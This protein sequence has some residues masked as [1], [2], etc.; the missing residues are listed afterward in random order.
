M[1]LL[2]P[3]PSPPL[4]ESAQG[5]RLIKLSALSYSSL[6]LLQ[7]IEPRRCLTTAHSFE[8]AAFRQYPS[9]VSLL[10][11][12]GLECIDCLTVEQEE[13]LAAINAKLAQ[14]TEQRQNRAN[15]NRQL[16]NMNPMGMMPPHNMQNPMSGQTPAQANQGF[17]SQLQRPMQATP[18][19][20]NH[21][22]PYA[23]GMVPQGMSMNQASGAQIM[24]QQPVPNVTLTEPELQ[25]I[26]TLAQQKANSMTQDDKNKV[27]NMVPPHQREQLQRLGDNSIVAICRQQI[28]RQFMLR[29]SSQQLRN[30]NVA[31]SQNMMPGMATMQGPQPAFGRPSQQMQTNQPQANGFH[32]SQ[33]VNVTLLGQQAEAQKSQEAGQVVVPASNNPNVSQ[34]MTSQQSMGAQNA[35]AQ[36]QMFNNRQLTNQQGALRAQQQQQQQ[37][38]EQ[39]LKLA[40]ANQ[41]RNM[42]LQGQ[43]GGLNGS[44]PPQQ[45]PAMPNLNRPMVPPGSNNLQS[46]QQQGGPAMQP[47]PVPMENRMSQQGH[48][49]MPNQQGFGASQNAA[50]MQVNRNALIPPHISLELR[51][52]LM[53]MPEP[54]FQ[55]ALNQ[56]QQSYQRQMA[57]NRNNNQMASQPQF[58]MQPG[59]V[60]MQQNPLQSGHQQL[61]VN[62]QPQ[63]VGSG[64]QQQQPQQNG[65]IKQLSHLQQ[66]F[67][68]TPA[69]IAEWD[70]KPAPPQIRN[71][72]PRL[73][74]HAQT[75]GQVKNHITNAALN[76]MM[77]T[78][79][80]HAQSQHF[81][82]FATQM[83][84][85]NGISNGTG[86]AGNMQNQNAM[87]MAANGPAPPAQMVAPG[88]QQVPP[89]AKMGVQ[90]QMPSAFTLNNLAN[91]NQAQIVA[92]TPQDL[93]KVRSRMGAKGAQMDDNTIRQ[94]LWNQRNRMQQSP[95]NLAAPQMQGNMMNQQF[96]LGPNMM[97]Q[98]R[99]QGQ[100]PVPQPQQTQQIQTPKPQAKP[101][102]TPAKP[103]QQA[104]IAQAQQIQRGQKRPASNDDVMEV[105]PPKVAKPN[106]APHMQQS[107]S[108]QG[109]PK[110]TPDPMANLKPEEKAKVQEQIRQ[111]AMAKASTN[112]ARSLNQANG[113]PVSAGSQ[114]AS[115]SGSG[116][117]AQRFQLGTRMMKEIHES[118]T[119]SRPAKPLTE[120]QSKQVETLVKRSEMLVNNTIKQAH[121]Y[122][123]KTADENLMRQ[124]AQPVSVSKCT[125]CSSLTF[126]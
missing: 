40:Q 74:E 48:M 102:Q 88:Q 35:M 126:A 94:M 16:G 75:W 10:A 33:D 29:K 124:I 107:K 25:Q 44:Q 58:S 72:I 87:S 89:Q 100:P 34:P 38:R 68:N 95:Q 83:R 101:G 99:P 23:Q 45:S 81:E 121:A 36:Q 125:I 21:Q 108:Q 76:P 123:V 105:P 56:I 119:K 46:R 90:P 66:V 20:Q 91:M 54:N 7:T 52:K 43:V 27:W 73:P 6:S 57:T 86:H 112:T 116:I 47:S 59:R 69:R 103:M 17:N 62:S 111:Q 84:A 85:Q 82:H 110:M 30:G 93:D 118:I 8:S 77:A 53:A 14:I 26:T 5:P 49:N 11:E 92:L 65:A 113:A 9:K 67:M 60:Q 115:S 63:N 24:Q 78:Q 51:Q 64:Q 32:E 1:R 96:H 37:L 28:M 2:R 15:N 13:Y 71:R 120:A 55:A 122:Y 39:Q 18:L 61:N 4:P 104:G 12:R 97:Q 3:A 114:V 31:P 50:A 70:Q 98:G 106:D 19:S 42:A 22:N 117:D 79:I 80:L 41:T 109:V